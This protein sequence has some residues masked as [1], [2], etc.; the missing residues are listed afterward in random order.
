MFPPIIVNGS[1]IRCIGRDLNDSSPVKMDSKFR[2][3]SIPASKRMV[4]PLLPQSSGVDGALKAPVDCTT[5]AESAWS[6]ETPSACKQRRVAAQSS[7]VE[8]FSIRDVPR[9][10]AAMIAARCETDLS[11]GI[12]RRPRI[13]FAGRMITIRS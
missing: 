10:S 8:K 6:I 9:A 12:C 2:P 1:M 13:L 5:T 3:A 7:L 11:P 4:V